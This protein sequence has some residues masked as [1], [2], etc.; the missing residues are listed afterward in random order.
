MKFNQIVVPHI[1]VNDTEVT[2][3]EIFFNDED[4]VKNQLTCSIETQ[5]RS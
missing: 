2:L 5:R 4:F 3:I 1:N